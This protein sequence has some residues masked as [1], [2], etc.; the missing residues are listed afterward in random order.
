VTEPVQIGRAQLY[1]GDCRDI[2]PTLGKVGAVVTDPPYPNNAGHFVEDIPA[3]LEAMRLVNAPHWLV[4][5]TEMEFPPVRQPMVAAHIWHRTNT[6]RPDNYEPIFEFHEDGKKRASRV[7]PYCVIFPGLTGI[8]ATGHPTEKNIDL[9]AALVKRTSGLVLDPFIGSGAT[10][11]AA[12]KQGRAFIGIEREP[13]YF[14]IACKR[15]EDA[16][17][18]GDFFVEAA[19]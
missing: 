7:F 19:A 18:Q 9:M 10:G 15:I 3:A 6:N 8:E 5:W 14:D 13:K 1:L 16:Q 11:V 4:F 17:R 2:L 12:V